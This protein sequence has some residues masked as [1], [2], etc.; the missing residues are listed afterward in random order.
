MNP[1]V[2]NS[3]AWSPTRW[4]VAIAGAVVVQ[5]VLILGFSLRGP[6]PQRSG[7]NTELNLPASVPVELQALTDPTLLALGGARSFGAIWLEP[8]PLPPLNADWRQAPRWLVLEAGLLGSG[9]V[10]YARSNAAPVHGL[11]FRPP[12]RDLGTSP[13]VTPA[14]VRTASALRVT[15]RLSD[16]P[17][18]T[19]PDLPS[20]PAPD[21]LPPSEV[22]VVVDARGVVISA[23]LQSGSGLAAADQYALQTARQLRFKPLPPG[24]SNGSL[25]LGQLTFDW[26]AEELPATDSGTTSPTPSSTP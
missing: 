20:W 19:A 23:I 15:G 6:I 2:E 25:T 24:E 8:A 12:P 16:R 10:E 1:P 22:R 26:R 21:V 5:V 14:P 18:R 3:T 4:T 7:R 9:F 17:L 11:V 13:T